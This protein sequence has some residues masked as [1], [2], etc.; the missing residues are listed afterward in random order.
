MTA[1]IG[2]EGAFDKTI[3]NSII[4]ALRKFTAEPV[5]GHFRGDSDNGE[6]NNESKGS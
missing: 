6:Y 3:H 5:I 1:F 4:R 2:I